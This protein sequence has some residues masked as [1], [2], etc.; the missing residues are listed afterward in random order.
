MPPRT[1]AIAPPE[2]EKLLSR[3]IL[4]VVQRDQT[5]ATPRIIWHH[6]F[7]I[8]EAVFGEGTVKIVEDTELLDE[9]YS[10]RP[11][12]ELM[13]HNKRQDK[14]LPPSQ[15]LGLGFV[16]LGDARQEYDRLCLVYGKHPD[17]NSPMAEHVYGRF[18]AGRFAAILGQPDLADL[19]DM[20]LREL[21]ISY[22]A[23]PEVVRAVGA[24]L[25]QIAR[26]VGVRL[27]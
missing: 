25:M 20:Q 1:P 15:T 18:Q 14:L 4:V 9:G 7:P 2:A 24:D 3:R 27:R 12:P 17:I 26:D 13:V 6:E 21:A 22:G 11:A 8:L 16:F 23:E 19:P 5:A 10:D